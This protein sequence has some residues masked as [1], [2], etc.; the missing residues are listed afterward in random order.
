[1]TTAQAERQAPNAERRTQG[2]RL[3]KPA[4]IPLAGVL[5]QLCTERGVPLATV[6]GRAGAWCDRSSIYRVMS[7]ASA[8]P[9]VS[10]LAAICRALDVRPQE[11]FERA[12]LWSAEQG[13]GA[14][15]HAELRAV[16]AAVA[17]LPD[18]ERVRVVQVVRAMV[19]AAHAQREHPQRERERSMAPSR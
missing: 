17:C 16:L 14:S 18:S 8:D 6:V 15:R 13:K 19:E 10:T 3:S 11:V 12:G 1:M 5:Q 2:G 7:G 4:P 9:L